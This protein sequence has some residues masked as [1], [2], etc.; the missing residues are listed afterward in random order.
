MREGRI[1]K[2][3]VLFQLPVEGI[4]DVAYGPILDFS[5]ISSPAVAFLPSIFF[6]KKNCV[7]Q[8]LPIYLRNLKVSFYDKKY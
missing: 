3:I 2:E 6:L 8:K 7:T 1:F 5:P 4:A